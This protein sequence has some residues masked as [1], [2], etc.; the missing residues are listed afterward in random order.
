MLPCLNKQFFGWDC[1]GC[2]TQRAFFLVLQGDFRAAYNMYPAIYPM[3]LLF[4][5][6]VANLFIKIRHAWPIKISLIILSAVII[7]G[8]YFYKMSHLFS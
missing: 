2:G 5:F 4:L 1:L 6:L 8:S 7:I 3:L